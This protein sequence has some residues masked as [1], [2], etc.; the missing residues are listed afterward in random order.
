MPG[1]NS[2]RSDYQ[3]LSILC[4]GMIGVMKLLWWLLVICGG[5][6][7]LIPAKRKWR[8][9]VILGLIAWV[10]PCIPDIVDYLLRVPP[11]EG[12]EKALPFVFGYFMFISIPLTA[13]L[14]LTLLYMGASGVLRS[15]GHR[16]QP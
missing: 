11:G 4:G 6:I 9:L 2:D 5:M 15:G 10:P 8:W 3:W 12:T 7:G 13:A 14:L 1:Y 16:S